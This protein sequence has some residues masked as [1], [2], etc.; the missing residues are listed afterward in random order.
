[1]PYFRLETAR[2]LLRPPEPGDVKAITAFM[3][4]DVVKNLCRAPHPY[5]E[6]HAHAFLG[7]Q[8]EG[9]ARGSDFAFAVTRKSDSAFA[10]MC[11]VHLREKGFELGYWLGRPHWGQGYATEAAAEVLAFAFRNLR[12]DTVEAGWFQDNPASGRV[13]EKIGFRPDGTGRRDC[14][15]RGESVLCNLV[16]MSRAEFGQRQAA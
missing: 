5:L 9:R 1:M 4:W 11:G 13:L 16:I 14:A 10:G 2:L 12:A 8:E 6:E 7:R 15:A 3:E